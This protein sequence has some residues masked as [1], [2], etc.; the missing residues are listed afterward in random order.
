[1]GG[2]WRRAEEDR[3]RRGLLRIFPLTLLVAVACLFLFSWIAEEMLEQDTRWFDYSVRT[4]VHHLATPNRTAFMIAMTDIGS[5][6]VVVPLAAVVLWI[7]RERQQRRET[8]LLIVTIVGAV[9][10]DACLKLAFHRARP[11][12]FFGFPLPRSYSFP[13]GHALFSFCF[14]G[15][16]AWIA[17]RYLAG[18]WQRALVWITAV[19][20]IG[21]IGLS[22]IYLGVHY[23][24]DVVAGYLA[25][26]V[27]VSAVELVGRR[28]RAGSTA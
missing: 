6:M 3:I 12:P 22:R 21:L 11:H 27:W 9:V 4:A 13:S 7:L 16:L 8:V 15:V 23:P 28:W 18:R 26:G 14:Y 1:M 25:A 20:L 5:W 19:I 2:G 24:S 17:T 10:L